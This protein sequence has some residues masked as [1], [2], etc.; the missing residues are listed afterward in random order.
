MRASSLGQ[1]D[2]PCIIECWY[3]VSLPLS[4]FQKLHL[5]NYYDVTQ[6]SSVITL[7]FGA[8]NLGDVL[9]VIILVMT[10]HTDPSYD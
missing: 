2:S 1:Y 7:L 6:E 10:L 5:L 9:C 4:K 8:C 3:F